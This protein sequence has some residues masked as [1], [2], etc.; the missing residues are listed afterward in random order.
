MALAHCVWIHACHFIANV[1]WCDPPTPTP[2]QSKYRTIPQARR[3][4][5][6]WSLTVTS[7]PSPPPPSDPGS[8]ESVLHL[9]GFVSSRMGNGIVGY[10]NGSWLH[11]FLRDWPFTQLSATE[12]PSRDVCP[13][14]TPVVFLLPSVLWYGWTSIFHHSPS[15]RCFGCFQFLTIAFEAALKNHIRVL[16]GRKFSCLKANA[17]R[18]MARAYGRCTFSSLSKPQFPRELYGQQQFL[19]LTNLPPFLISPV[20]IGIRWQL[21]GV[22]I[23][24]SWRAEHLF[25]PFLPICVLP[26][27]N[28]PSRLWPSFQLNCSAVSLLT[29]ESAFCLLDP[30]LCRLCGLQV[31]SFRLQPLHHPLTA[32][33]AEKKFSILMKSNLPIF[34]SCT[35]MSEDTS[36]SP[37]SQRLRPPPPRHLL[38]AFYI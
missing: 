16:C 36:P 17:R 31:W 14:F 5:S 6:C 22:V 21:L 33:S 34:V 2:V 37:R 27:W 30:L 29:V 25:M 15:Q 8:H 13:Q 10:G 28:A 19:T 4:P 18:A 38:N 12:I 1:D 20:L 3:P 7:A 23:C 24:L 11:D 32:S 35:V 9:Y 26:Q